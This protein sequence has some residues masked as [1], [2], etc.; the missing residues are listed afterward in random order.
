MGGVLRTFVPSRV[1]WAFSPDP[2]LS[3]LHPGGNTGFSRHHVWNFRGRTEDQFP[4]RGHLQ[5]LHVA[6]QFS[7]FSV[8]EVSP[9][10]SPSRREIG[11]GALAERA[12]EPVL[13]SSETFPYTIRIVSEVLESNGSSSMATVCGATLSLMDGGVPIKAPVAELP[14]A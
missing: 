14:W 3:P 6:L 8:G 1:K 5:V 2:W 12:I 13:P 7:S 11:H 10:R 4:D 9:L